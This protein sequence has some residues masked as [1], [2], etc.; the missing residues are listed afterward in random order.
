MNVTCPNSLFY[1]KGAG[2]LSQTQNLVTVSKRRGTP[3][4]REFHK[5]TLGQ[6]TVQPNGAFYE[7]SKG[8]KTAPCG[9]KFH[10]PHLVTGGST[11][12]WCVP[13]APE[14]VEEFHK[15]GVPQASGSGL[16]C[17]PSPGPAEPR[18]APARPASRTTALRGRPAG[19]S[20]CSTLRGGDWGS[21]APLVAPEILPPHLRRYLFENRP[22]ASAPKQE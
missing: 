4:G 8:L 5:N 7:P 2:T 16:V 9:R 12:W 21:C 13:W 11:S 15:Q 3:W 17:L 10:K 22:F 6:E 18:S 1:A 20:P 19:D 14:G